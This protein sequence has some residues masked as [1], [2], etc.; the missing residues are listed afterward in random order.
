L[1][2]T[3]ICLTAYAKSREHC[4]RRFWRLRQRR[5]RGL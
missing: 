3:I 2:L 4:R 5:Y 1:L